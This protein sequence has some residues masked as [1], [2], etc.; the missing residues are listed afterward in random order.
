[1]KSLRGWEFD[2][3]EEKSTTIKKRNS[4]V[5]HGRQVNIHFDLYLVLIDYYLFDEALQG[6]ISGVFPKIKG[7]FL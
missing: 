4:Y 1:M 6:V 7:K 2:E 3:L 5:F